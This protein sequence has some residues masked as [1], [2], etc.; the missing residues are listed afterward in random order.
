MHVC[1]MSPQNVTGDEIWSDELN[2][3]TYNCVS[4]VG[5]KADI[6][7]NVCFICGV[8]IQTELFVQPVYE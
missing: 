6:D 2:L 7:L 3:K 8:M 4:W 5:Q 1:S